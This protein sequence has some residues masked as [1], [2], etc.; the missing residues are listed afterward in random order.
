[1]QI[2]VRSYLSAGTVAVV[3]A[4]AIALAPPVPVAMP[5]VAPP[6]VAE[7]S[8]TGLNLS[9]NQIVGVLGKI[10][11]SDAISPVVDLLPSNLL[12]SFVAE[13]SDQALA[14]LAV[15][16]KGI[17]SDVGSVA[18]GLIVGSDS[19]VRTVATAIVGMPKALIDAVKALGSGGIPATLQQLVAGVTA[20]LTGVVQ[21]INDAVKAIQ[22]DVQ[23]RINDLVVAI[24]NLLVT[25]VKDVVTKDFQAVADLV[26]NAI[27]GLSNL[28][29][30]FQ[31]S[32]G[33]ASVAALAPAASAVPASA[34][35][36]L[37][38]A[39]VPVSPLPAAEVPPSAAVALRAASRAARVPAR[40]PGDSGAPKAAAA[41][42]SGAATAESV[43][44]VSP[45]SIVV[46]P[47]LK[48]ADVSALAASRSKAAAHSHAA[49]RPGNATSRSAAAE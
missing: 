25:V 44:S 7:V 23:H 33:A 2:S 22:V 9:L 21:V 48:P 40:G 49:G 10:G 28:I 30:R 4:G 36:A 27:A 35:A 37:P 5:T 8:L 1:M 34:V 3:G 29:G 20:P 17:I 43:D 31:P 18:M 38:D 19:V 45:R 46:K 15:A 32:A 6:V 12:N 16:A 26:K 47:A 11:L 14:L 39:A 24:P 41:T 13:F 42:A